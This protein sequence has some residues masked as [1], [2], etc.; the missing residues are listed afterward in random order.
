MKTF[1]RATNVLIFIFSVL[2]MI[3]ACLP[4]TK[5]NSE[6]P[7][8][9]H[10]P[11]ATESITEPKISEFTPVIPFATSFPDVAVNGSDPENQEPIHFTFPTP[12]PAPVSHWRNPLYEAPWALSPFDHFMFQRPIAADEVNWPIPDYRYGGIF[13]STDIIHTGIDLPNP[14]GTP[15]LAAGSGRVIWVGY[16]L[17]YGAGSINDPYGLAVV[18]RHDFG[19]QGRK[20]N[21]VYAHMDRIDVELEQE[22]KAGDLIGIIG[23]TGATTGPHLHFEIRIEDNSFYRTRNPELW[24]VP[25]QD[26]GLIVGRVLKPNGNPLIH[27]NVTIKSLESGKI[28]RIVTYGGAPANSDDYYKENFAISDLQAGD[29]EIIIDFEEKQYKTQITVFPGAIS[30]FTFQPNKGYN[31]DFPELPWPENLEFVEAN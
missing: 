3:T 1:L 31:F 15:V 27:H 24:I 5:N 29:Y 9:N 18:I 23:T 22:V 28:R 2:F 21:T 19:Y 6:I 30:Y 26:C 4:F 17:M 12:Q 20:L 8:S 11:E 7:V 10:T 14:K 25:A 13:F 16:G